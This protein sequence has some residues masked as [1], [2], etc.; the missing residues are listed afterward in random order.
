VFVLNITQVW[1]QSLC[2]DDDVWWVV[3]G[4]CCCWCT[5]SACLL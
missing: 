2:S 4:C 3:I 5:L 1:M